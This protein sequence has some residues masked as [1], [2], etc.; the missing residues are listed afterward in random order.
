MGEAKRRASAPPAVVIREHADGNGYDAIGPAGHF[1]FRGGMPLD[2]M[3]KDPDF[4]ALNISRLL[5]CLQIAKAAGFAEPHRCK[6][7]AAVMRHIASGEPDPEHVQAMSEVRRDE[8]VLAIN[9]P[10]G[11]KIVDGRHRI[12][13]RFLDGLT[14]YE[15]YVFTPEVLPWVRLTCVQVA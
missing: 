13:R 11:H 8:P 15:V 6:L 7:D 2:H 4:G 10:K 1:V 5:G 3:V 12:T 9:T 14:D